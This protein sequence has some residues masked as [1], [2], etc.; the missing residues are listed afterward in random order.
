[1]GAL[2]ER[3]A[4]RRL[5]QRIEG[6]L[7]IAECQEADD[8]LDT[9]R[10]LTHLGDLF[11]P[12]D[13]AFERR[14]AARIETR[15][16]ASPRRRAAWRFRPAW[17]AAVALALVVVGL[18]TP[19][20]RSVVAELMAIFS[21]GRT[22]VRVE[23]ELAGDLRSFTATA[24]ITLPGLPEAQAT[25]EPRTLW[26]PASLPEGYRLHR[27]STSHFDELP[28]WVQPLF[29]DVTYRR[30]TEEFVWELAYRQYFVASGGPGTIRAL[31]Y[32]PEEF[33]S[34]EKVTVAGRPAVL[35]SR[36]P[37]HSDQ[38]GE[39]VLHLVW[40]GDNTVFTLTSSELSPDALVQVAESVSPCQ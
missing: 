20:G 29:V 26:V 8:L 19:P 38:P 11:G 12:P 7:D 4:A 34:V 31:T 39:R 15:L 18:F 6:M 30:E 3:Q 28:A 14:L 27:L 23:P 37:A 16:A 10:R 36:S 21:L 13:P 25:V 24:E 2:G 9:A 33:E 32:P 22:E 35:L 1:M 40:E 17:A 5:A